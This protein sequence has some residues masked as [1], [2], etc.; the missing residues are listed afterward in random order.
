MADWIKK[1]DVEFQAQMAVTVPALVANPV[2]YGLVAGD[3]STLAAKRTAF[4][5]ALAASDMAKA[6]LTTAVAEKDAA[7]A[8]LQ[9]AVRAVVKVA[10]ASPA[11]TDANRTVAGIPVV[12][13]VRTSSVPVVP[14]ALV[15]TLD[16]AN[17]AALSWQS[18]GNASGISYVIEQRVGATGDWALSDV[19]SATRKRVVGLV[20]GAS[21]YFRVRARRGEMTSDPSNVV[22]VY[23]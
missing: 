1:S 13:K 7:R 20:A 16:G 18:N 11:V 9:E 5:N 21:V 10:Q 19:V 8:A 2:D 22:S 12:D 14:A 15:A 23:A 4:N 6:A 17:A 3:V